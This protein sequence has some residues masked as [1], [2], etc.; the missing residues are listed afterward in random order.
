MGLGV[1]VY[2]YAFCCEK[3]PS[4][5]SIFAPDWGLF[6]GS[7]FSENFDSFTLSD[8]EAAQLYIVAPFFITLGSLLKLF[9]MKRQ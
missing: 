8:K 9:G 7:S 2:T 1:I 4:G 5:L 3:V 6:N